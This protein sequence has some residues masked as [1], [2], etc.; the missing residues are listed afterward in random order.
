MGGKVRKAKST[1]N[2][3]EG[4]QHWLQGLQRNRDKEVPIGIQCVGE[5]RIRSIQKPADETSVT[6]YRHRVR[7]SIPQKKEQTGGKSSPRPKH[8]SVYGGTNF[9]KTERLSACGETI[10]QKLV[11]RE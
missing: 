2:K 4:R 11:S 1:V 6:L 10:V 3:G 5:V 9:A 7:C 8:F